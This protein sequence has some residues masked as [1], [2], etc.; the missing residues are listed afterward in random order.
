M[1]EDMI[2]KLKIQILEKRA[3]TRKLTVSLK[4]MKISKELQRVAIAQEAVLQTS[5]ALAMAQVAD[6]EARK[7]YAKAKDA[8]RTKERELLAPPTVHV[9]EDAELVDAVRLPASLESN[10][11]LESEGESAVV[12]VV[13]E[14]FSLGR[15]LT[16]RG[17]REMRGRLTA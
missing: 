16:V 15:L 10:D 12:P 8:W 3:R 4:E 14:P 6:A 17:V 1:F 5:Q 2:Y 13:R 9:F 11:E 7:E